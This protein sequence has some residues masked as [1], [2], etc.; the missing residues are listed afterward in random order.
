MQI[1]HYNQDSFS[2]SLQK[3]CTVTN[4]W[5]YFKILKELFCLPVLFNLYLWFVV[6]V[7]IS[8]NA[9]LFIQIAR[10]VI[11]ADICI[12][13]EPQVWLAIGEVLPFKY[14]LMNNAYTP[15]WLQSFTA[16]A[17][18]NIKGV[19]CKLNVKQKRLLIHSWDINMMFQNSWIMS[20]L[21]FL[22]VLVFKRIWRLAW[23]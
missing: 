14:S 3:I 6:V 13:H 21:E 5:R 22:L 12:I 8:L 19:M 2:L 20:S 9:Y 23:L 17:I 18:R 11:Y 10:L 1:I 16:P 15:P 7:Y 4:K